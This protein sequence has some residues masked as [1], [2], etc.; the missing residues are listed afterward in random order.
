MLS[1]ITMLL[2]DLE[3]PGI[4]DQIRSDD[5]FLIEKRQNVTGFS[6]MYGIVGLS[7]GNLIDISF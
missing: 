3:E 6:E 5:D 1:I 2:F 7:W 4:S